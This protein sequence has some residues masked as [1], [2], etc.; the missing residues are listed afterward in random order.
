M[1]FSRGVDAL[2]VLAVAGVATTSI[3]LGVGIVPTYPRHPVAL[4]QQAATVQALEHFTVDASFVVPG[5]SRVSV[6]VG[7]LGPLMVRAAGELADG[8]VTWLVGPGALETDVVPVLSKAAADAGR[9]DPRVVAGLPVLV[10][11]DVDA[12]RQRV[13]EVFARY[14]TLANYQRQFEREGVSGPG[15]IALVGD[16]RAVEAQLRTLAAAGATEIW[17]TVFDLDTEPGSSQR[18]VAL[19]RSL[20]PELS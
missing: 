20:A 12:G 3:E 8:V 5:T 10:C 19:L 6:V 16:E 2:S 7:A 4:A 18:T 17:P 13:N 9:G 1:H 14:G 11:D 15:E